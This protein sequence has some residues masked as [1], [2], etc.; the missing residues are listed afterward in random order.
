MKVKK[1]L[2]KKL[3]VKGL[4]I[5]FVRKNSVGNMGDSKEHGPN[6]TSHHLRQT[7][8]LKYEL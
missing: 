6:L 2:R 4:G 8:K 5:N 3:C 7:K 1:L